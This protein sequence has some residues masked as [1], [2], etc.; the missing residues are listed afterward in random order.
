M[1]LRARIHYKQYKNNPLD[2]QEQI[3]YQHKLL[4]MRRKA[5]KE[6]HNVSSQKLLKPSNKLAIK[7][8]RSNSVKRKKFQQNLHNE[9]FKN[10]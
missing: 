5:I 7:F 2:K 6:F 8:N 10:M 3:L 1:L 4:R 9:Y